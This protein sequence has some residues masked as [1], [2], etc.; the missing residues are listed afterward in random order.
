MEQSPGSPTCQ[1]QRNSGP[2]GDGGSGQAYLSPFLVG[3]VFLPVLGTNCKPPRPCTP[4][5]RWG[6]IAQL[7][8]QCCRLGGKP[9]N[10]HSPRGVRDQDPNRVGPLSMACPLWV[11]TWCSLCT[12][13]CPPCV[14]GYPP[15]GVCL[16][17]MQQAVSGTSMAFINNMQRKESGGCCSIPRVPEGLRAVNFYRLGVGQCS[18]CGLSW[19]GR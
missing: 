18:A 4:E 13:L 3:P 15:H 5:D 11:L 19:I 14:T 1:W 2:G 16:Y 7:W 6:G 12:C 9:P 17:D 10:L 8:S